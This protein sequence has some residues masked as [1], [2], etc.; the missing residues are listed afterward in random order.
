[1]YMLFFFFFEETYVYVSA[2]IICTC[3]ILPTDTWLIGNVYGG[4][5]LQATTWNHKCKSSGTLISST[6]P[7]H[8]KGDGCSV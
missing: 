6:Q 3:L 1:M 7:N 4:T 2:P 8:T 5:S